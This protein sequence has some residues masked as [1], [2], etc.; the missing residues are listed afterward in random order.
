MY[1]CRGGFVMVILCVCMFLLYPQAII[2]YILGEKQQQQQ[3][4]SQI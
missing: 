4:R 3:Q 1:V 2:V